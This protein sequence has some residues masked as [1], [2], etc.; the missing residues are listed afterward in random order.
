MIIFYS[1][2]LDFDCVVNVSQCS[3]K[4]H[5][6][7]ENGWMVQMT[8]TLPCETEDILSHLIGQLNCGSQR[9]NSTQHWPTET[10]LNS[11][12]AHSLPELSY[13]WSEMCAL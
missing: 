10:H 7:K 6:C 8:V 5:A 9:H 4:Q 13:M 2:H 12:L 1:K 3:H 11:T